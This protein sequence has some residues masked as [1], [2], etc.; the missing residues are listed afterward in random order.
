MYVIYICTRAHKLIPEQHRVQE[1]YAP[2][3]CMYICI[4]IC[5]LHIRINM[6]TDIHNG[7]PEQH[8]VQ[9]YAALYVYVYIHT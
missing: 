3:V 9:G 7:I 6:Y 1:E 2:H 8:L 5:I 4:H